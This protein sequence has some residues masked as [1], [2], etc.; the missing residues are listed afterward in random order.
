MLNHPT[1]NLTQILTILISGLAFWRKLL[2]RTFR[3]VKYAGQTAM[4]MANAQKHPCP[5]WAVAPA[6]SCANRTDISN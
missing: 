2:Y 4:P 6:G 3:A 1:E 5:G